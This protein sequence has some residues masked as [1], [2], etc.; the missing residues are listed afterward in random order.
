MAVP[1]GGGGDEAESSHSRTID[2][3]VTTIYKQLDND[4]RQIRLLVV[5]RA[6]IKRPY[7]A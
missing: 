6:E 5:N 3:P 4:E 1:L 2:V 7:A